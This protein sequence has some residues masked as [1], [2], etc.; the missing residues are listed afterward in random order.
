MV[1]SG[2]PVAAASRLKEF[3]AL[4]SKLIAYSLLLFLLLEYKI[5]LKTTNSSLVYINIGL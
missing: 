1:I 5:S 2:M 4:E 3:C